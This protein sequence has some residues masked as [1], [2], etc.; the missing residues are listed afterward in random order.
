MKYE[1]KHWRRGCRKFINKIN[2]NAKILEIQQ[3]V[4]V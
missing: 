2:D 3:K 4:G 1:G